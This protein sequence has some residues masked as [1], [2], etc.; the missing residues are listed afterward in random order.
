M[1]IKPQDFDITFALV[2]SCALLAMLHTN[3]RTALI[4][5][6]LQEQRAEKKGAQR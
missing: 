2:T 3:T 6:E 5:M 4:A 1:S